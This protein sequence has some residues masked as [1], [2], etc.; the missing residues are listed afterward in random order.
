MR[1]H[2]DFWQ[3]PYRCKVFAPPSCHSYYTAHAGPRKSCIHETALLG[4]SSQN[5]CQWRWQ[6]NS[7][8]MVFHESSNSGLI[9]EET[10]PKFLTWCVLWEVLKTLTKITLKNGYKVMCVN[11]EDES[12]DDES[13]EGESSECVIHSMK[14][15]CVDTTGLHRSKRVQI[16]WQ[17]IHQ[18]NLYCWGVV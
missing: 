1:E 11:W 10:S 7:S 15:P 9:M 5:T 3:W 18:E 12:G 13:E 4:W 2:T 16:Q 17:Y 14:L 8:V 6:N